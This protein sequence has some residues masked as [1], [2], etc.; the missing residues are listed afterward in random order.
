MYQT[1]R[2]SPQSAI[3]RRLSALLLTALWL[4]AMTS[5]SGDDSDDITATPAVQNLLQLDAPGSDNA[6]TRFLLYAPEAS[7]PQTL[8]AQSAVRLPENS[9]DGETFL[10]SYYPD[11][12][13]ADGSQ[14]IGVSGLARINNS[15][16]QQ[17]SDDDLAGWDNDPVWVTSIWR[18]GDKINMRLKLAYDTRPRQFALT[19]DESTLSDPYPTAY[20][21]HKRQDGSDS[22]YRQYYASFSC[23]PLWEMQGVKGVKIRVNNANNPDKNLFVILSPRGE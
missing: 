4:C 8:V 23:T 5:C 17:A 15:I 19:V 16:I 11:R 10:V 7:S 9:F 21:V 18:A 14:T 22:F 13:L 20:L 3:R 1:A 12:K 6:T 2:T